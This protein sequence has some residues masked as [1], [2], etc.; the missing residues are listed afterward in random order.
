MPSFEDTEARGV[1]IV[2]VSPHRDDA[3]FSL[4]LSIGCW[5][6]ANHTVVV[7]NCFTRSDYA[8]Y[9]DFE[10][11]HSNDRMPRVSALRLRE[12]EAWQKMYPRGL[13]LVDLS[14]KDAPLR[15]HVAMN[16]VIGRAVN[17]DDKTMTKLPK[18]VAALKPDALVLPLALGGHVDHKTARMAM[19]HPGESHAVPVAFYED[20]PYAAWPGIAAEIEGVA[21]GLDRGVEP[22]FITDGGLVVTAV[23]RKRKLAL[24]YDSQIA[25]DVAQQIATFSAGYGGRERLWGNA[26]WRAAEWLRGKRTR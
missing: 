12:D 25:D 5:I 23:E 3:C 2:V 20:L 15:L 26:T 18:A 16:E 22:V 10:F 1:K 9:A 19:M 17:P 14:L 24:C 7:V 13:Q 21:R 6:E 11:I 4:G 8:P